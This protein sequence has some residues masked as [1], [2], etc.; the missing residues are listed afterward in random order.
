[1]FFFALAVIC[2]IWLHIIA[3]KMMKARAPELL[4]DLEEKV[5]I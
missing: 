5:V 1:M 2:L 3:R 4:S